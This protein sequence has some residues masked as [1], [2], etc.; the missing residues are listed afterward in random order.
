M[1]K[2]ASFDSS[3]KTKFAQNLHTLMLKYLGHS[4]FSIE[5]NG[6]NL[7]IDPFITGNPLASHIDIQS[8]KADY[9]LVS[10][11]HGDHIA[12]CVELAKITNAKV[13]SNHEIITWLNGFGVEGIAMNQGGSLFLEFGTVKMVYA[14]HS[15]SFP[16]GSYAGHSNGFVIWN[17]D[18]CFYFAG[19]TALSMEMKLLPLT[20]PKLDFAILP[21][22]DVFT[23]GVDDALIASQFC[24]VDT[25]IAAHFDTFPP[26]QLDH[27]VAEKK[28]KSNSKRLIIPKI[29][30]TINWK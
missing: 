29:G 13:I 17:S 5:I 24:E 8:L 7:I 15:S 6:K 23:M 11:G 10:H 18:L 30:E 4:C 25:I 21:I 12:D 26:I 19:D 1:G 16:D 22:G 20:C 9:I 3:K 14:A 28:F 27:L 2:S